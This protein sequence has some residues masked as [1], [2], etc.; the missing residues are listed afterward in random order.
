VDIYNIIKDMTIIDGHTD[1]PRDVYLKELNGEENV[2]MNNHYAHLK[3]ASVNIVFANIF[4]K[5]QKEFSVNE[6]LLQIEK[7]IKASEENEDVIIIKDKKDLAYVIETG[8]LGVII[9]MEGFEPLND[10]LNLLTIYYELGLRAGMLTWNYANSFA[11]G[12]YNDEGTIT[13]MGKLVIDKMNE[14]GII[15]DVSHLNEVGFWD[16][17]KHNKKLTI[18]SHSNSKVLYNHKR[19]LTDEQMIGI[20]ES[21][22]VIGAVSYFSKVCDP[23]SNELHIDDDITENIHDYI[24]HIEY[25]VNLV[26]YNHV[27]FGFDFNIYLGDFGVSGLESVENIKDVIQLLLERGHKLEDISKIA[28]GNFLRVLNEI[29]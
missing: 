25:M 28:G 11:Y 26:G 23:S 9:S 18:A 27:A 22:G 7:I 10:T 14:L 4:T 21:G 5:T 2:F 13:T 12:S 1:F 24:Q 3:R 15:V 16:V 8:K 29:L 20:A 17:I 19:N 6:T